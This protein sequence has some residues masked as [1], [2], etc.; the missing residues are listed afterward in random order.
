M[1]QRGCRDQCLREWQWQRV[2]SE[3]GRAW[4]HHK[5]RSLAGR[6]RRSS[7]WTRRRTPPVPT[8]G[9]PSA[10]RP[11]RRAFRGRPHSASA[12][13]APAA[14]ADFRR[15]RLAV[16]AGLKQSPCRYSGDRC[17]NPRRARA[18]D[19]HKDRSRT[20][21][22]RRSWNWTRRGMLPEAHRAASAAEG[23]PGP[24]PAPPAAPLSGSAPPVPAS[25]IERS[26]DAARCGRLP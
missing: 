18:W 2:A 12:R 23:F 24:C 26:R 17:W 15:K 7:S 19:H 21:R 16:A 8:L 3:E 25:R 5:D 1:S 13:P 22:S 14:S 20:G 9:A 11:S 6:S 10:R 4:E